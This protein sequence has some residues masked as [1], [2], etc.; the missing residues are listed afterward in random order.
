MVGMDFVKYYLDDV[1]AQLAPSDE[2]L[3]EA[4]ARRDIV[5]QM[6]DKFPGALR[7]F[8]SGSLAH[9]TANCPIH[10]RDK[11]LDADCG[12]VLDRRYFPTLG[13][14]GSNIG[15]KQV[16]SDICQ[17]IASGV[18]QK[19]PNATLE[20]TKRAILVKFYKPLPSGEDPTVDLIVALTRKDAAGLWIPNTEANNW[21]ASHP[22][23]HTELF[24]TGEQSFRTARAQAVRLA[25]AANKRDGTPLLCSFNIEALALMYVQPSMN[26]A[27]ALLAIWKQGAIDLKS[28]LTPDPA[29]V[30]APIKA[31]NR[32]TAVTRFSEFADKLETA[33]IL[34]SDKEWVRDY[35][36]PI[37]P[38]FIDISGGESK[39]RLAAAMK[40][41]SSL[42]ISNTGVISTSI[43]GSTVLKHP[44]SFGEVR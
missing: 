22:E 39:A 7:S 8:N 43:L 9:A 29:G 36:Q 33:L 14:D 19:Y 38:S 30:S 10:E 44:R 35:L 34:P 23:R 6:A 32:L 31:P 12:I 3:Q 1:R 5:K 28:R 41:R 27:Q 2:V 21:D 15:P 16:I 40:S 20:I 4:R 26:T 13:P 11:G 17:F 37:W 25:K 42:T 18:R 24:K